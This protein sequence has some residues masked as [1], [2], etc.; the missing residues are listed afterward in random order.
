MR[1]LCLV[2]SAALLVWACGGGG[3]TTAPADDGPVITG[4]GG[5]SSGAVVSSSAVGGGLPTAS[6]SGSGGSAGAGGAT[7]CVDIALGEPNESETTAYR[8]KAAAID[9]CDGS[10]DTINGVIAG[11]QDV[12]WYFYEGDDGIG[13]SVDPTRSL[14]QSES[15]LRICK[16]FECISGDTEVD[17]CP[18]GTTPALSPE[19]RPGCCGTSGFDVGLNCGGTLDEHAYVYI[20]IDQPG[21]NLATCNGY[22][23]DYHY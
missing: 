13:C 9:D 12:D 18:S 11:F 7:S 5:A 6:S 21:G 20:R 22:S 2:A 14:T 1:R 15:G 8:L 23:L 17:D 10:G 4:A 16:Y 3:S 19:N